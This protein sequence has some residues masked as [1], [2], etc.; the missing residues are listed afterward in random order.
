MLEVLV[1]ELHHALEKVWEALTDPAHL[2]E[3]APF[4]ADRSLGTA[5][6]TVKLTT[7]R[8]P[9]API[10]ETTVTDARR[11]AQ[12]A[13]NTISAATTS[14]GSSSTL[15]DGTRLTLWHSIDQ[16]F[17]AMPALPVG[18]FVSTCWSVLSRVSRS[19]ASSDLRR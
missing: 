19:G 10:S 12:A 17:I 13:R 5:G 14:A 2:R 8:T 15:G 3:W 4:D 16:R 11:R 18:T 7:V 6:A 1:R 9:G